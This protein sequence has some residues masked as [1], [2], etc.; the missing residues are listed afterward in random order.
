M[1]II[2]CIHFNTLFLSQIK[3]WLEQ[4]HIIII[5]LTNNAVGCDD[6]VVY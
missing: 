4:L 5:F 2:C 1:I 6:I 3:L